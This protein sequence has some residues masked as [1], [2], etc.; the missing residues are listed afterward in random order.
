MAKIAFDLSRALDQRRASGERGGTTSRA[1]ARGDGWAV[2]DV[3]CTSGPDDHPF[4]ERHEQYSI[5]VVLA[6]TFQYRGPAGHAVMT[7]GS[8]MLGNAGHCFE[9]GHEHGEGDRCVSFWYAPAYIERIAADAGHRGGKLEFRLPR[10]PAVRPL[11]STVAAVAAGVVGTTTSWEELA[12]QL[13]AHAVTLAS[14]DAPRYRVPR[15]AEAAVTGVIRGIEGRPDSQLAL[16]D[17]ARQAG[18][19]PYHFLRTFQRVAGVTPHQYLLRARLR[20][21]AVRLAAGRVK[22]LDVALDCGFGDVSNFNRAFRAEFGMS[23]RAFQ[24]RVTRG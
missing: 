12:I 4:E 18:L 8:L 24:R 16:I 23:P 22:I 17:M 15:G 1:L 13:A 19:S 11:A 7:P 3:V 6:G 9:C 5:A 14:D 21:A 10:V 2:A 20:D